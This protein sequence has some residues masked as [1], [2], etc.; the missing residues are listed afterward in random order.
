MSNA[1]ITKSVSL[2]DMVEKGFDRRLVAIL[3]TYPFTA[4]GWVFGLTAVA[5]PDVAVTVAAILAGVYFLLVLV[6][7]LLRAYRWRHANASKKRELSSL[8]DSRDRFANR[9]AKIQSR[10]P[11]YFTVNSW[12]EDVWVG[13]NG[14]TTI[15]REVELVAGPEGIDVFFAG[16][17]ST[18]RPSNKKHVKVSVELI[19]TADVVPCVYDE[20]WVEE[21]RLRVY[22]FLARHHQAGEMLTFRITFTWPQYWSRLAQGQRDSMEWNV[23]RK[24]GRLDYRLTVEKNV[25][26][27]SAI[28]LEPVVGNPVLA[29]STDASGNFV[30]TCEETGLDANE[31]I[32]FNLV[33]R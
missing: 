31:V 22:A 13:A 27:P 18:E 30:V 16:L 20:H 11:G 2:L 6:Y 7:T 9:V 24:I 23:G 32:K 15:V 33:P 4:V 3:V 26:L 1:L 5:S 14:D 28:S 10:N 29:T 8:R 19:R 12:R 21:K 17:F 25:G